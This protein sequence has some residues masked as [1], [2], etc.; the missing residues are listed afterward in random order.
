MTPECPSDEE[1]QRMSPDPYVLFVQ[2]IT[3]AFTRQVLK[4]FLTPER[5]SEESWDID[6]GP[7][8]W[9]EPNDDEAD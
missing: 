5:P 6:D 8:P 1:F 7:W 3:P 9:T 4:E 2:Q